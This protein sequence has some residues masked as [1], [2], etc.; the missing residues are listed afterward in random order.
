MTGSVSKLS[1]ACPPWALESGEAADP[2]NKALPLA[3]F[4]SAATKYRT[5]GNREAGKGL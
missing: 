2:G 5:K 1:G 4:L 3:I